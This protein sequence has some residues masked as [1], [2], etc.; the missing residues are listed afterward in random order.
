MSSLRFDALRMI[1]K[2][3]V[4]GQPAE[5]SRPISE[6]FGK[7]VFSHD[8]MRRYLSKEANREFDKCLEQDE[9]ISLRLADQIATAMK[10]W[11]SEKGVTHYTHWFQPLNGATAEKHDAFFEFDSQQGVMEQFSGK[12]LVQQ[13]PDASSF[14]SGGMRNT[15]EARG[16]TGWDPSS[17]AFIVDGTLCIP[18]VFISYKGESLDYKTPLLRSKRAVDKAATKVCQLFD[19]KVRNV[20]VTLGWEQE[21]FL[22]DERLFQARPDLALTGRTLMGHLAAKNQQ[23]ED[24]YFGS[25]P[26]RVANYMKD[27][28]Y[29]AHLLGI[30]LKT[31]HN[32]VAPGQFEC[33]PIF[34]EVNIAVDHNQLL[35]DLMNRIARHHR[36]R[37]LLH[38]KPFDGVNGS[39]K[40]NNWSMM[41]DTGINLLAPGNAPDKNMQF[42]VFLINT[43]KAVHDRA[44]LLK[45]TIVSAGNE[46]RLGANEAPPAIMSVFLGKELNNILDQIEATDA[47]QF[48]SSSVRQKIKLDIAN[49][50]EL[51]V[52]NTDRNRTSPFAF[53]GNRF[54]FRAVGSSANCAA[55]MISLNTAIAYQLN[56]FLNELDTKIKA[57]MDADNAMFTILQQYIIES[58]IIRFE[59]NGYSQE[60]VVEATG[61]GLSAERSVPLVLK[62]FLE[63]KTISM[64]ESENVLTEKEIHARHEIRLETFVK[65]IQIES[66]VLGD[67]AINH[68]IPVAIKYQ[69]TLLENVQGLKAVL[70]SAEYQEFAKPH[71]QTIQTISRHISEIRTLVSSMVDARKKANSLTDIA[72]KALSYDNE[73]KPHFDFIRGHVDKLELIC[74][75]N[76]WPLPKYRELLFMR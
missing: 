62:E 27:F 3:S 64:F 26:E 38:E 68:I 58:K 31:R 67:L 21:Y 5:A 37:V 23:L 41:T 39:G 49:I 44:E 33:A 16:Y 15:F 57:G 19:Q 69:N 53:T 65:N 72:E 22:V 50:P 14:P 73:V 11:A 51:L 24:H 60:W 13:E 48:L 47:A 20:S 70:E 10:T 45:A 46:H 75:D 66:R 1:L 36:F 59:G 76:I 28:E 40:H 8:K 7:H 18:T 52:D 35:M 2:D 17:P 29:H 43:V 12:L 32:E 6:Y 56:A 9:P 25:I 71:I 55:P 34:E 74:D 54:E 61:R 4:N 30:P 42:L 63:E